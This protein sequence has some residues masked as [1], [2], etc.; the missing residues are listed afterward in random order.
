M[1]YRLTITAEHVRNPRSLGMREYLPLIGC[2]GR[3]LP[4][5]VGKRAYERNGVWQVEN[6]EQ[7]DQRL[8]YE[9]RLRSVMRDA[10]VTP[11]ALR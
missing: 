4:G 6:D 11:G 10:L 7:R 2:M 3:L 1:T 8:A 9:R 5:D